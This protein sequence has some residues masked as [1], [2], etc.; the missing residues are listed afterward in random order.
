MYGWFGL[1]IASLWRDDY[2][3]SW[4]CKVG[5]FFATL[6]VAGADY[7]IILSIAISSKTYREFSF[8]WKYSVSF[9]VFSA[10]V[11][12]LFS[13][14]LL[15]FSSARMPTAARWVFV[16]LWMFRIFDFVITA[17]DGLYAFQCAF[18]QL[19]IICLA[20]YQSQHKFRIVHKRMFL[21]INFGWVEN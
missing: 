16:F 20:A 12:L 15:N 19:Q 3:L 9:L 21:L 2:I 8:W 14:S 13:W 17:L 6:A 7:N 5:A 1:C 11:V 4:Q 18:H 10:A